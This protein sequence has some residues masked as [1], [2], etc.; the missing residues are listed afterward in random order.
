LQTH[1]Q[2][3]GQQQSLTAKKPH[4]MSSKRAPV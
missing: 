2:R 3:S 4:R 1:R